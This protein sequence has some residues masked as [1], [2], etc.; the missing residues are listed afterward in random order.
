MI[1]IHPLMAVPKGIDPQTQRPKDGVRIVVDMRQINERYQPQSTDKFS[2]TNPALFHTPLQGCVMFSGCDVASHYNHF[3]LDEDSKKLFGS[4]DTRGKTIRWTGIPMGFKMSTE[5]AV[6]ITDQQ[7]VGPLREAFAKDVVEYSLPPR[8][9]TSTLEVG[10]RV[11]QGGERKA[12]TKGGEL[13]MPALEKRTERVEIPPPQVSL[14]GEP[15]EGMPELGRLP[16]MQEPGTF[17]KARNS[18]SAYVDNHVLGTRGERINLED[19]PRGW[20][21]LARN[22]WDTALRPYLDLMRQAGMR[23][24]FDAD[25]WFSPESRSMGMLF[26]GE[27]L[28]LMSAR[29]QGIADLCTPPKPNL[30]FVYRAR[31]LFVSFL[32]FC[33]SLEFSNALAVLTAV[34]VA[35]NKEGTPVARLWGPDQEEA[36]RRCKEIILAAGPI[37]VLDCTRQS[38]LYT[39]A[40]VRGWGAALVQFGDKGEPRIIA[41]FSQAYSDAQ[42]GY[43]VRHFEAFAIVSALRKL[44]QLRI[45]T[46]GTIVRCDHRNLTYLRTS[47]DRL[48]QTW[49]LELALEGIILQ[50]VSGEGNGVSDNL[51]RNPA[52]APVWDTGEPAFRLLS[53]ASSVQVVETFTEPNLMV[54]ETS[55]TMLPQTLAA[56]VWDRDAETIP[57]QV[58]GIASSGPVMKAT[59]WQKYFTEQEVE[60]MKANP[61]F[62]QTTIKPDKGRPLTVWTKG[63]LLVLPAGAVAERK[64]LLR[65]A[66]DLGMHPGAPGTRSLLGPVW[67]PNLKSDVDA[68]IASCGICQVIKA[69]HKEGVRGEAHIRNPGGPF[70]MVVIDHMM[71]SPEGAQGQKAVVTI[72][73]A[74]TRYIELVPVTSL[75]A[76]DTQD[77]LMTGL[78]ARHG[79]PKVI[80]CDNSTSYYSEVTAWATGHG[81]KIHMVPPRHPQ[82]NGKVERTHDM[83]TKRLAAVTLGGKGA[84]WPEALPFV[85][86]SLNGYPHRVTGISPHEAL[87][88]YPLRGLN[89]AILDFQTT[90]PGSMGDYKVLIEHIQGNVEDA[91]E[92]YSYYQQATMKRE[93]GGREPPQYEVG[94]SVM[95]YANLRQPKLKNPSHYWPGYQVVGKDPDGIPYFYMVARLR[96]NGAKEEPVRMPVSRLRKYDASRDPTKGTGLILDEGTTLFTSIEGHEIKDKAKAS[97]EVT[98]RVKWSDGSVSIAPTV[99]IWSTAKDMLTAYCKEQRIPLACVERQVRRDRAREAEKGPLDDKENAAHGL[100]GGGAQ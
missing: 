98:F 100:V 42:S 82:A 84:L 50:H 24:G 5:L 11:E 35:H 12:R 83:I 65:N 95:I 18:V 47:T 79:L 17:T 99:D 64:L 59:L 30:D 2:M 81:V 4:K 9:D 73:D 44:K 69:G 7:V 90:L 46:Y 32:R 78:F 39:D 67:W 37:H 3:K 31:G 97:E 87:Y 43:G 76:A 28:T 21:E 56:L 92:L 93:D 10:V 52:A 60:A 15:E 63:G 61:H 86:L 26:D 49:S 74:F 1:H 96:P 66:H 20:T 22:H 14:G 38:Y 8:P 55:L 94:D 25:Q 33:G 6:E 36:F 54:Q 13:E 34:I 70:Q 91:N 40:S 68:Y 23:I 58:G 75:N 48:L 62:M 57:M 16:G 71:V 27:K 41:A 51:S 45:P 72:Q 88:G 53:P 19:D 77:A 89:N 29:L 85:Q 80:Q